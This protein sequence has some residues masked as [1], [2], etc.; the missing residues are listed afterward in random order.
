MGGS[1]ERLLIATHKGLFTAERVSTGWTVSDVAFEGAEVSMLTCDARSGDIYAALRRGSECLLGRSSD[2]GR[3]YDFVAFPAFPPGLDGGVRVEL[4]TA[5]A[6]LGPDAPGEIWAGTMPAGLFR[7]ADRGEHWEFVE[8]LWAR[9]ERPLFGPSGWGAPALH[10]L[11]V[12]PRDSQRVLLAV[13]RGGV[14]GTEDGG[15]SFARKGDGLPASENATLPNPHRLA[16]CRSNPD[17]VWCQHKRGVLRST[18][19]GQTFVAAAGALDIFGFAIAA[20]PH[21]G[22]T[23]WFVPS[24]PP[25]EPG[26]FERALVVGKT[27]DAGATV[28]RKT[29]GLP[30]RFAYDVVYRHALEVDESGTLLAMGSSTGNLFISDDGAESFQVVSHHLP[31]IYALCFARARLRSSVLPGPA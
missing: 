16:R 2:G 3:S 24:H 7:S 5:L 21:D 30:Q 17:V 10:S 22:D 13:S 23:A 26:P 12:D 6:A 19:A 11:L 15:K 28:Q 25:N 27:R 4:V 20:H 9:P 31:P 14:F 18:D 8:S 29:K 1:I